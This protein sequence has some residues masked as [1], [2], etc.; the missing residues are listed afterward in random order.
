MLAGFFEYSVVCPVLQIFASSADSTICIVHVGLVF[1]TQTP[2]PHVHSLCA[3]CCNTKLV[4]GTGQKVVQLLLFPKHINMYRACISVKE[5]I[6]PLLT[7]IGVSARRH[8]N[9]AEVAQVIP[10]APIAC[11]SIKAV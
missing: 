11:P 8:K 4:D 5:N 3:L 7:Y 9:F 6:S 2:C 10:S 1:P